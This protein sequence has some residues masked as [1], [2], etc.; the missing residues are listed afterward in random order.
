M[1]VVYRQWKLIKMPVSPVVRTRPFNDV[2][3]QSVRMFLQGLF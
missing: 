3:A 2:R 1:T